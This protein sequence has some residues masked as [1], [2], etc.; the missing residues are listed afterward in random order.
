MTSDTVMQMKT[1]YLYLLLRYSIAKLKSMQ[2]PTPPLTIPLLV[3]R[4]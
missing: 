4:T 2:V 3:A 1:V